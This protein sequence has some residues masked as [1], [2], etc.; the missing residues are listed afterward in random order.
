MADA[1]ETQLALLA[2]SRTE[3][4]LINLLLSNPRGVSGDH[5]GETQWAVICLANTQFDVGP[6]SFDNK[7]YCAK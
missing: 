1:Q 4:R 2:Q 6:S 5:C 3:T 7:L